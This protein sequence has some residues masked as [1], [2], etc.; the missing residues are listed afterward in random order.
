MT[1]RPPTIPPTIAPTL[2]PDL[3]LEDVD[4]GTDVAIG[5]LVFVAD[6]SFVIVIAKFEFIDPPVT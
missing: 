2:V 3:W 1:A 4:P 6:T 5:R